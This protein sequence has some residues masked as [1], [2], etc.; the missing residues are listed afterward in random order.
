MTV[1]EYL[2]SNNEIFKTMTIKG[3][4]SP[5][6]RYWFAVYSKYIYNRKEM[7]STDAMKEACKFYK[8][9]LNTGWNIKKYMERAV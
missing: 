6:Y 2:N 4:I 7:Q 3:I 8:L 5:K 1:F 9:K